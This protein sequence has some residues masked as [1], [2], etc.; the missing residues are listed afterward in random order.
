MHTPYPG[1][2]S[3]LYYPSFGWNSKF[4]G[5]GLPLRKGESW[6]S[7]S[8]KSEGSMRRKGKVHSCIPTLYRKM[9]RGLQTERVG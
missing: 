5:I 3:P 4:S 2:P 1:S 6:G 7:V 9:Q 8:Q